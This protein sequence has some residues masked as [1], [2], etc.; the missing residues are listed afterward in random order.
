MLVDW[1]NIYPDIAVPAHLLG[2]ITTR[3]FFA[4]DSIN[5]AQGN[6]K[7]GEI[8]HALT[9]AFL[10]AVLIEDVREHIERPNINLNNTR[11]SDNI[12]IN[13]LNGLD[14]LVETDRLKFSKWIFSCPLLLVYLNPNSSLQEH[15]FDFGD[16]H[17]TQVALQWSVYKELAEISPKYSLTKPKQYE[18]I[19]EQ[20]SELSNIG[21]NID[22]NDEIVIGDLV[23]RHRKLYP[24]QNITPT[25]LRKILE[26]YYNGETD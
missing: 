7:L 25:K 10:N 14:Y 5:N 12:L 16:E 23:N 20:I 8:M 22:I 18:R 2:K 21:L 4:A 15:I 3:F 17:L 24:A 13:N 19:I 6:R 11:M 1:N 9:V 26:Y